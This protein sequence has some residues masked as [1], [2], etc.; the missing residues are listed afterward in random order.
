MKRSIP[1]LCFLFGSNAVATVVAQDF[2]PDF[3]LIVQLPSYETFITNLGDSPIRVDGYQITSQSGSL[4]PD[5]WRRLGS[6]GPE[7]VAAL[8]P[9][10]DLFFAANPTA[11]VLLS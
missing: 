5:G 4:N 8:G 1:L 6:S 7:I 3:A 10:A 11:K 9:G 2:Y